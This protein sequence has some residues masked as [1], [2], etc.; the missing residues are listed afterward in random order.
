MPAV[1]MGLFSGWIGIAL[2]AARIGAALQAPEWFDRAAA[3]LRRCVSERSESREFDLIAGRAG[4]IAGLLALLPLLADRSYL[5]LAVALG[6]EL[7]EMADQAAIGYSWPSPGLRN[8]CNLTGFSHGAAG[9]AWALLEL[10]QAT[11]DTRYTSAARRAFAYERHFF[12]ASASNW[13]DF[14]EDRSAGDRRTV[15]TFSTTWCHGAP[16]IA[17][18]RLRAYALLGDASY[19]DEARVALDTTR[20][21]IRLG[22]HTAR[23]NYSLCHGLAGNAEVLRYAD[24]VLR[25]DPAQ[26][27]GLA[28]EVANAGIARYGG[29]GAWPCGTHT[30]ETPNLMLGLAGIGDFYLRLYH[31]DAPSILIPAA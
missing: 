6:D 21:M 31:G 14:R 17:L 25:A 28:A 11:G 24:A 15:P 30:A 22:L 29:S 5:E 26:G 1:R 13:P 8:L 27:A 2:A 12:D 9:A 3:L 16:G 18:S 20:R 7:L 4:G 10:G 19:L 23:G